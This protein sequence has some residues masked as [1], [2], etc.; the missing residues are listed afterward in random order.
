MKEKSIILWQGDS[1]TDCKRN[2]EREAIP[3][4][5]EA[6][7]LGYSKMASAELLSVYPSKELCIYNRGKSGDRI[8]DLYARWKIDCLNLK[9]DILSI[10]I[11]VNDTGKERKDQP[12]GVDPERY[13]TIYRMLL[14]WT[15]EILPEIQLV[16]CEPFWLPLGRVDSSWMEEMAQ[17]Q[18]IVRNLAQEFDAF[19][20]PF[21]ELF[22]RLIE[23]KS[24]E[25]WSVDGVHPN[26][27]GHHRMNR[28]WLEKTGFRE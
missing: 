13:E 23:E 15:K 12:N 10:L 7:G 14:E 5:M 11:G 20:V 19:F 3:S 28:F 8:V 1:I 27:A 2:R 22:D 26:M 21:Q 4:D 17:R 9:P 6:M 25:Y 24:A 16:L 18:Y